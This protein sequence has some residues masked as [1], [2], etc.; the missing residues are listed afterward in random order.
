LIWTDIANDAIPFDRNLR[1]IADCDKAIRLPS[2]ELPRFTAHIEPS[3][4]ISID[5]SIPG[6]IRSEYLQKG[7]TSHNFNSSGMFRSANKNYSQVYLRDAVIDHCFTSVHGPH[8][9]V[10][11]G[12]DLPEIS[13]QKTE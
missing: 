6:K 3:S 10:S 1:V 9:L 12:L 4:D 11:P 7:T 2:F 8:F 13:S 5:I